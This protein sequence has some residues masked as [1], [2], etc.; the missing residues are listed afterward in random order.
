M[1]SK[2]LNNFPQNFPLDTQDAVL[3]FFFHFY[4]K[5]VEIF[6]SK[7]GTDE[8]KFFL[9]KLICGLINCIFEKS[10]EPFNE[11]LKTF[12]PESQNDKH[13]CVYFRKKIPAKK[14]SAYVESTFNNFPILFRTKISKLFARLFGK[15]LVWTA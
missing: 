9:T 2:T 1:F 7:S 3:K 13:K 10:R 8:K 12:R 15:T 6:G 14:Y 4:G 11:S 5:E